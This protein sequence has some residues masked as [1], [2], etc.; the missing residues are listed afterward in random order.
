MKPG[1]QIELRIDHVA[2]GGD[3]VGRFHQQVVFVPFTVDGDEVRVLITDIRKRFVRG[4]LEKL[5]KPS[6]N[7][8]E[9]RCRYYARFRLVDDVV[10][11]SAR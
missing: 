3:G 5:L 11:T 8:I 9:P 1:D 6:P 4:R 10:E 7:R 2:F